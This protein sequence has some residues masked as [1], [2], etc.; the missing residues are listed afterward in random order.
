MMASIPPASKKF[1]AKVARAVKA[2]MGPRLARN[3][4]G[5][6]PVFAKYE[7]DRSRRRSKASAVRTEGRGAMATG[8]SPAAVPA[9]WDRFAPC[10]A[11]LIREEKEVSPVGAADGAGAGPSF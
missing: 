4:F 6:A 5:R 2:A 1:L 10:W 11:I 9:S 7:S 3:T 8:A